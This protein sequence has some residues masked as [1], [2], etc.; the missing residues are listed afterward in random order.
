[1]SN[2]QSTPL[3]ELGLGSNATPED[4]QLRHQML[5]AFFHAPSNTSSQLKDLSNSLIDSIDA[6]Y[7]QIPKPQAT[8]DNPPPVFQDTPPGPYQSS[9]G[10]SPIPPGPSPTPPTPEPGPVPPL[11]PQ[12]P[13]PNGWVVLLFIVGIVFVLS[14]V[15][16]SFQPKPPETLPIPAPVPAPTPTPPP[17]PSHDLDKDDPAYSPDEGP[18]KLIYFYF[19]SLSKGH[20]NHAFNCWDSKWQSTSLIQGREPRDA[21]RQNHLI[22]PTCPEFDSL[23]ADTF[24]VRGVAQDDSLIFRVNPKPFGLKNVRYFDYTLVKED[25]KWRIH[26]VALSSPSDPKQALW[27]YFKAMSE[28]RWDDAIDFYTAGYKA[29]YIAS[30]TDFA[31]SHSAFFLCKPFKD[32]PSDTFTVIDSGDDRQV[33]QVN[34]DPFELSKRTINYTL[35]KD[36]DDWKVDAVADLSTP[37]DTGGTTT[38]T[39]TGTEFPPAQPPSTLQA[40]TVNTV[41]QLQVEMA[42]ESERMKM[43][44]HRWSPILHDMQSASDL[45]A[46]LK[47]QLN[48]PPLDAWGRPVNL[49]P[50]H[51]QYYQDSLVQRYNA[52]QTRYNDLARESQNCANEYSEA[53]QRYDTALYRYNNLAPQIGWSQLQS[54]CPAPLAQIGQ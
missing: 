16:N 8:K 36:G 14:S 34:T 23:P 29:K 26:T 41:K 51:A 40:E 53:R 27:S 31:N 32:L 30:S 11:P 39:T 2:K 48:G 46:S 13:V 10:P 3:H 24:S 50:G 37:P 22:V 44:N 38:G 33:I 5:S 1:M 15:Y 49:S 45:M 9:E 20:L 28:K 42:S 47:Q 18:I 21:F 52:Q 54:N 19:W 4:A 7:S 6:A 35:A 17:S 43:A 25:G 12:P